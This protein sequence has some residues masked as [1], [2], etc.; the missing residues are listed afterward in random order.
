[1]PVNVLRVVLSKWSKV[2]VFGL[3][4]C[5]ASFTA[6]AKPQPKTSIEYPFKA[7]F[8][9][10]HLWSSS[11]N[12]SEQLLLQQTLRQ[13]SRQ[14]ATLN[15]K[16]ANP[17]I[18]LSDRCDD[19]VVVRYRII[20]IRHHIDT[21]TIEQATPQQVRYLLMSFD[22]KQQLVVDTPPIFSEDSTYFALFKASVLTDAV[23]TQL[24][25]YRYDP[26]GWKRELEQWRIQPCPSCDLNIS[27][28]P[29]WTDRRLEIPRPQ[30]SLPIRWIESTYRDETTKQWL[31]S[32]F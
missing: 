13:I 31:L 9:S 24:S 29:R 8:A 17:P 21:W 19:D 4:C 16:I 28:V 18:Q 25:I 30:T 27:T 2:V 6:A 23:S 1:M 14:G 15:L 7:C 32:E 3:W 11:L 10:N 12:Q 5:G 22:G 20:D 26:S